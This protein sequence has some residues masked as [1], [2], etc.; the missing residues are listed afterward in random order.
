LSPDDVADEALHPLDADG[1]VLVEAASGDI[2]ESEAT[3]LMAALTPLVRGKI[4]L[5]KTKMVR[6]IDAPGEVGRVNE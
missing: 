1:V 3:A 4:T 5:D 6:S 2:I